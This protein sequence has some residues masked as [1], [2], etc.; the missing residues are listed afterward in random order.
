MP[1]LHEVARGV[2]GGARCC[3]ILVET[4][5]LSDTLRS[6]GHLLR[7]D[8]AD[9]ARQYARKVDRDQFVVGR[10]VVRQIGALSL[11]APPTS[12]E[13]VNGAY[14]KPHYRDTPIEFNVSH[15]RGLVGVGFGMS[16]IGIDVER[17]GETQDI[18]G[19]ASRFFTSREVAVLTAS[20][21]DAAERTFYRAWT[22]KEAVLKASGAGLSADLGNV[23]FD[24]TQ[25]EP[26]MVGLAA[27]LGDPD[28][29]Y[30]MALPLQP[31]YMGS[32]A[33]AGRRL[34]VSVLRYQVSDLVMTS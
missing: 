22:A 13:L 31:P 16:P 24:L 32:L 6:L 25:E 10:A 15:T 11:G 3:V 28:D 30:L 18:V 4:E 5:Q 19:I 21:P 7:A 29:W 23:E 34:E 1:S 26:T 8:E 20:A 33:I 27:P 12:I 17:I 14:G 9:R 2:A